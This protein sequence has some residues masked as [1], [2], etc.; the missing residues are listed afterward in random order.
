MKGIEK[1]D[2]KGWLNMADE[3]LV[4]KINEL[5]DKI[6]ELENKKNKQ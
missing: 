6:N 5:I 3:I 1:L 4:E 2:T